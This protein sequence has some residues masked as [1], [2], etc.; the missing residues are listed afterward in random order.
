MPVTDR[1]RAMM[2]VIVRFAL[3]GAVSAN[4]Y[5]L[6]IKTPS[7]SPPWIELALLLNWVVFSFA[8][9]LAE[10]RGDQN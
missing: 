1:K 3:I 9:I 10:R 4:A 8:I 6:G 2:P 5:Y 7:V